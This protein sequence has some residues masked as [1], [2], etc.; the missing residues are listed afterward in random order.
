MVE[1][2]LFCWDRIVGD[3]SKVTKKSLPDEDAL[4]FSFL[5]SNYQL[6]WVDGSSFI[7]K[8]KSDPKKIKVNNAGKNAE[9]SYDDTDKKKLKCSVSIDGTVKRIL[10]LMKSGGKAYVYDTA[11]PGEGSYNKELTEE[12]LENEITYGFFGGPGGEETPKEV[13]NA[14]RVKEIRATYKE[15]DHAKAKVIKALRVKIEDKDGKDIEIDGGKDK[16]GEHYESIKFDEDDYCKKIIISKVVDLDGTQ[17]GWEYIRSIYIETIG[18]RTF[19][20]GS[21]EPDDNQERIEL[22]E[23]EGKLKNIRFYCGDAIDSIEFTVIEKPNNIRSFNYQFFDQAPDIENSQVTIVQQVFHN[24]FSNAPMH[25]SFQGSRTL[26]STFSWNF[27]TRLGFSYKSTVETQI[28]FVAK[29]QVELGATLEFELGVSG[30]ERQEH[31]YSWQAEFDI[32]Q[33]ASMEASVTD[34]FGVLDVPFKC[35]AIAYY[36]SGY[37]MPGY[38]EGTF[39]NASKHDLDVSIAQFTPKDGVERKP[40]NIPPPL[41]SFK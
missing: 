18:G 5:E 9:L 20:I 29:G 15:W 8:N 16:E 37:F 24:K 25:V 19:S 26:E 31:T 30:A 33:N 28:P 23:F 38:L 10:K 41:T 12:T 17:K 39:K 14:K 2:V 7:E 35:D 1:N 34:I 4:L 13:K 36:R 40:E 6:K 21:T 27:A 32:P 22:F 11:L 3:V